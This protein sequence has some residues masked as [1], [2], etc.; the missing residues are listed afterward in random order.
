ML[1]VS[2]D[3]IVDIL[4]HLQRP[5]LGVHPHQCA[6]VR[7][8]RS[9]CTRCADACPTQAITWQES[10]KVEAVKCIDCGVCATVCPT[11]A[12]EAQAPTNAELLGQVKTRVAENRSVAFACSRY[13][14]TARAASAQF[15][16]VKCLGRLDE[17]ILFGAIAEGAPSV[18]LLDGACA[19]CPQ[20]VGRTIAAQA[21]QRANAL[22]SAFGI[23][24]QVAFDA[25]RFAAAETAPNS[26][27]TTDALSRR[28]FFDFLR[29]ETIKVAAATVSGVLS[30]PETASAAEAKLP[31]G[32]LPTRVPSKYQLLLT[33]LRK[34]GKPVSTEWSDGIWAHFGFTEKCNGCQMCA[35]FCPT[36]ALT[37]IEQDDK[38]GV[39]F[40][41]ALCADC[42]LCQEMC[43]LDGVTLSPTVD[44]AQ[45]VNDTAESFLMVDAES[46]PWK[47]SP[48]ER[49]K[50]TVLSALAKT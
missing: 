44:L 43:Y 33:A 23:A 2:L 29:R 8:R 35:F 11:G 24:R 10:L 38:L 27:A 13:L 16:Q 31:V 49:L 48:E 5:S 6:R 12:L 46:A 9:T 14:E 1:P 28:A 32:G 40:Q 20:A 36:G 42:R 34:I 4:G 19:D 17:S 50:K 26:V 3:R 22:L 47:L 15:V 30:N 45:V 18:T 25:R 21:V 41:V 39:T 37:K 7:H